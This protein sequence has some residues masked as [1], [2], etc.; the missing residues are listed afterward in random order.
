MHTL[1]KEMQMKRHSARFVVPALVLV[2]LVSLAAR[3][4]SAAERSTPAHPVWLAN[5]LEFTPAPRPTTCFVWIGTDYYSDGTLTT[6]VG[7]CTVTCFQATHGT[8]EPTFTGG[9]ACTGTSSSFT[10]RRS[11]GCPGICP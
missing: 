4:A 8:A 10:V 6:R 1:L 5:V 9:G 11:F 7:Q 3:Q 2:L